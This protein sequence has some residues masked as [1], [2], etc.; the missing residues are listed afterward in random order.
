MNREKDLSK[1]AVEP[2][3]VSLAVWVVPLLA[4]VVGGWMIYKYYAKLGPQIVITFRQ[5]G[6]LEPKNSYIKFRDVKV[7]V[8]E[9]VE[10]LKEAEGVKV[11]ARMNR[12]VAPFLN[13]TT[14]FWIVRPEIGAGEI[15]GLDALVSGA[16][17]E[18]YAKLGKESR[19]HFKGLLEPPLDLEEER[20]GRQIELIAQRSYDLSPGDPVYYRQ[21]RVGKVEQV[22]LDPKGER[23]EF[24]IFVREPYSRFINSTSRFWNIDSIS[25]NIG[26]KGID[27]EMNSLAQ[28]VVGGIEFTTREIG[29]EENITTPFY[30]YGSRGKA[31]RKR[32][33]VGQEEYLDFL[34][35]FDE[36][37]GYLSIGAPV[38]IDGFT[39]GH[40]KDIR[41][42]FNLE[43]KRIESQVIS[44]IDI[45]SFRRDPGDDGL[46]NLKRLVE[47]GLKAR[48]RESVPFLDALYVELIFGD[49]NGSVEALGRGLYSFP[50]VE[51]YRSKLT[52]TVQSI[53]RKIE[54]IP[55]ERTLDSL[56]SLLERS[57]EPLRGSLLALKR[58]LKGVSRLMEENATRKL[59]D[60]LERTL[61]ELEKAIVSYRELAESYGKESLFKEKV[62]LLLRD[63]DRTT[64]ELNRLIKKLDRKP[65]A[66]IF[67]D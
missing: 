5:S 34:M 26:D 8:V 22:R 60:R 2:K 15:R 42:R 13:E 66:L 64:R 65:N 38:K 45:A 59:P 20:R 21:I 63:L 56:S 14:K 31:N 55:I 53:L 10:I 18:M 49:G 28:I 23:V 67:G 57:R 47:E 11:I 37:V 29:I 58:T 52:A 40:V 3:R 48:L 62:D 27:V 61:E 32:V 6:G 41:S 46:A 24:T 17:I 16:Y 50:T 33:G 30:L 9:R 12:D 36:N 43:T 19:R 44:S 1:V 4:L 7:G 54:E 35:E 25:L 51:S 39:I